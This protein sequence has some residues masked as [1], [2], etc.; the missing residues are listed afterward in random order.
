MAIISTP[1]RR[2]KA[3]RRTA[4]TAAPFGQGLYPKRTRFEPSDEDRRW[5]AEVFGA[6][7]DWDVRMAEGAE[8]EPDWDM[9]AGEAASL[10]AMCALTP[11][12][13]GICKKCGEPSEALS[14][15]M[16]PDCYDDAATDAAIACQN[17]RA[18]G[19]FRVF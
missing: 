17:R 11:P 4:R 12:A 5:A 9:L 6:D 1:A 2:V 8:P 7:A 3:T 19:Q 15:G 14:W 16:C 18:M 13:A 10:D